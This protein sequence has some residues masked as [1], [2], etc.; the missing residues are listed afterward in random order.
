MLPDNQINTI[1]TMNNIKAEFFS[2]GI[3]M[4]YGKKTNTISYTELLK[5][6]SADKGRFES[7]LLP[8]NCLKFYQSRDTISMALYYPSRKFNATYRDEIFTD[9]IR[10]NMM[11]FFKAVVLE[12]KSFEIKSVKIFAVKDD[13]YRVHEKSL[14]YYLPFPNIYEDGKV[15]W[16]RNAQIK[17]VKTLI[18]TTVILERYFTSVFNDDLWHSGPWDK[19][20]VTSVGEMFKELQNKDAF[21]LDVLKNLSKTTTVNDVLMSLL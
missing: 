17:N 7:H 21:P 15:C 9:C 1:N 3:I 14:L 4:N 2:D 16:G 13:F 6:L 20:K 19:Y 10:P 18:Q 11:L 12:D 5:I 8:L